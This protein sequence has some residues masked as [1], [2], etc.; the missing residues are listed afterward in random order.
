MTS[1]NSTPWSLVWQTH[2]IGISTRSIMVASCRLLWHTITISP[3]FVLSRELGPGINKPRNCREID[4]YIQ[5]SLKFPPSTSKHLTAQWLLPLQRTRSIANPL[6]P[7]RPTSR[8]EKPIQPFFAMGSICSLGIDPLST[9]GNT[10]KSLARLKRC[11][12]SVSL[13]CVLWEL[14][15]RFLPTSK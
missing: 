10:E 2:T 3:L 1:G 11:R 4:Q 13:V 14:T 5:E 7:I 12:R 9:P 6:R 15:I 8:Q